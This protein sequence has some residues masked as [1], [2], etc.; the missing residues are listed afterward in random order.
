MSVHA[1][2]QG[3][4]LGSSFAFRRLMSALAQLLGV[5]RRDHDVLIA[6]SKAARDFNSYAKRLFNDAKIR[7]LAIDNG[8]EPLAYQE[9]EKY[10]PV[11]T[12]RIFRIE[13]LIKR[14]LES[15]KSYAELVNEFESETKS[16]VRKR[17]FSGFKTVIAYRTGLDISLSDEARARSS[18]SE[19]MKDS[20]WF[21]PKVKPLRDYL[22]NI[23]AEIASKAGAFLQIHTGLGDTDIL[24]D[25]CNPLLLQGFL[26]Q[27]HILKTPIVLIHGGFPYT[28]EAAWLCSMFPNLYFELSSSFPPT[29]LPALSKARFDDA[30]EIVP[31]NRIVYGS[32]AIETPEFHWFS[33][34][35]AKQALAYALGDLV[36]EHLMSE[37]EAYRTA[38]KILDANSR[39]LLA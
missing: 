2:T 36:T 25:R 14:L 18:F 6:R 23:T 4:D 3:R 31:T 33:A 15:S 29:F 30:L 21:G 8:I 35:L 39:R 19:G 28:K 1:K 34:K 17:G 13:P 9:F 16:A 37:D 24:G 22:V 7:M 5:P 11:K 27:D 12:R 32:D 26:K 10:V 38:D 20:A